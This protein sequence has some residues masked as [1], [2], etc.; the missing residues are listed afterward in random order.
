MGEFLIFDERNVSFK[1]LNDMVS[2]PCFYARI[3]NKDW[4][5]VDNGRTL[6]L[7]VD[8]PFSTLNGLTVA[9]DDPIDLSTQDYYVRFIAERS[10]ATMSAHLFV[11]LTDEEGLTPDKYKTI[12]HIS[13]EDVFFLD[14]RQKRDTLRTHVY[15][16]VLSADPSKKKLFNSLALHRQGVGAKVAVSDFSIREYYAVTTIE[17]NK[18]DG[19]YTE[20]FRANVISFPGLGFERMIADIQYEGEDINSS[21]VYEL[22]GLFLEQQ[23]RP[24]P[25]SIIRVDSVKSAVG[26]SRVYEKERNFIVIRNSHETD[27]VLGPRNDYDGGVPLFPYRLEKDG[28]SVDEKQLRVGANVVYAV[29]VALKATVLS[30]NGVY[31]GLKSITF[32][33][34]VLDLSHFRKHHTEPF[35]KWLTDEPIIATAKLEPPPDSTSG[36][37]F[38]L[39]FT[40]TAEVRGWGDLPF[41]FCLGLRVASIEFTDD[42]NGQELKDHLNHDGRLSDAGLDEYHFSAGE[43]VVN[44]HIAAASQ[45]KI[46]LA[47]RAVIKTDHID[48]NKP[49]IKAGQEDLFHLAWEYASVATTG[50][51]RGFVTSK[52]GKTLWQFQPG[53]YELKIYGWIM[54]EDTIGRIMQQP[55]QAG[56]RY[57]TAS[58]VKDSTDEGLRNHQVIIEHTVHRNAQVKEGS[59]WDED[60]AITFV[61]I[62]Q[63]FTIVPG[64]ENKWLCV[65]IWIDKN[66]V[67]FYQNQSEPYQPAWT[68]FFQEHRHPYKTYQIS[69]TTEIRRQPDKEYPAVDKDH[70]LRFSVTRLPDTIGSEPDGAVIQNEGGN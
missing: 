30:H 9:L 24:A 46:G 70:L 15:S 35:Q 22:T 60:V 2:I 18:P 14:T 32:T 66:S 12:L 1:P 49:T 16:G 44:Q 59:D 52:D 41:A 25:G 13:N 31:A 56:H 42:E 36:S 61:D 26:D 64:S 45:Y 34:I 23:I 10:S 6:R 7:G 50:K 27:A 17:T 28:Q 29:S 5:V 40:G 58:L 48:S 67:E 63:R 37:K 43:I 68:M 69:S 21:F 11:A 55:Q 51:E 47:L 4:D 8:F 3:A 57:I 33:L 54:S 39:D 62:T 19:F 20:I 53:N 38:D 65:F